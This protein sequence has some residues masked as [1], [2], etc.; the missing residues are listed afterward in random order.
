MG[1]DGQLEQVVN[2]AERRAGDSDAL[3]LGVT[4]GRRAEDSDALPFGRGSR[5]RYAGLGTADLIERFRC[6]FRSGQR[7]GGQGSR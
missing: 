4:A 1:P 5:P 2:L 7:S 6:D 3:P